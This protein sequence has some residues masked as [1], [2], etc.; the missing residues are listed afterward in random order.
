[1]HKRRKVLSEPEIRYMVR[2]IA[3][4]CEYLHANKIV[5]RDLKL[6]N[7]FL[8]EDMILKLGDFGLATQITKD[9]ER[10]KTLCGTPNYI[11]PEVILKKGHAFEVDVWS[12]GCIVYTLYVGRPPFEREELKQTY[13]KIAE[14]DYRIPS[15]VPPDAKVLIAKMLSPKP[16]DRPTMNAI[17]KDPYLLNNYIPSKLPHSCLTTAPRFY[18]GRMSIMP[19]EMTQ[20]ISPRKPLGDR[21]TAEPVQKNVPIAGQ[22]KKPLEVDPK[23]AGPSNEAKNR[24]NQPAVPIEPKP[25]EEMVLP[26]TVEVNNFHL[27]DLAEQ[28][29]KLVQSQPHRRKTILQDEAE[30]PALA[31]FYWISK[32][33]DYTDR[34]G[35]A[36]QLCDNSIGILFNDVTRVLLLADEHNLQYIDRNGSEYFYLVDKYPDYLKKKIFLLDHF[37]KYMSKYLMKCGDKRVDLEEKDEM[38]RLPY[39]NKWL[40]TRNALIFQLTNGTVQINFFRDHT[41]LILC[42]HMQAV[43]FFNEPDGFRTYKFSLLETYGCSRSLYERLR[44]TKDVIEH[45]KTHEIRVAQKSSK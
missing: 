40:R 1:M 36:Y 32:W 20:V 11:A 10:K 4:A 3:A 18:N 25:Q 29:K 24:E 5:H 34:Y 31:P 30:D 13:K 45:L 22:S 42:P 27:E 21:N 28:L 38:T 44:Y 41:K 15:S 37:K 14:N 8:N 39:L 17:L 2:Q 26:A 9:N 35:I 16:N 19:T 33:V 23:P 7:L 12:L 43:T 6:G